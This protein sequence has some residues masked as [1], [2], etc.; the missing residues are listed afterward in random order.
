MAR[1]INCS[2]EVDDGAYF[3]SHCGT[4]ITAE[5]QTTN[6]C[7]KCGDQLY[8]DDAFC[9]NCGNKVSSA[10][11]MPISQKKS[12]PKRINKK[13]KQAVSAKK[14][15]GPISRVFRFLFWVGLI[16]IGLLLIPESWYESIDL[17]GFES[18]SSSAQVKEVTLQQ[19]AKTVVPEPFESVDQTITPEGTEVSHGAIR[20]I[21][22]PGSV[23]A[24]KNIQIKK[25]LGTPPSGTATGEKAFDAIAIGEPYDIGPDGISFDKPVTF[26]LSYDPA[27]LPK[28]ISTSSLILSY[29]D[30][31]K[32]VKVDAVHDKDK[33][34]FT[35]SASVFP[36]SLFHIL[37][38]PII[39]VGGTYMI[40]TGKHK[41]VFQMIWD[42]IR[43]NW[44]HEMVKPKNKSVQ[45]FSKRLRINDGGNLVSMDD[46]DD[47][48]KTLQK[49]IKK[50]KTIPFGFVDKYNKKKFI[51]LT[52]RYD[53]DAEFVKPPEDYIGKIDKSG[54]F[55]D[56]IDMTNIYVSMLRAKGIQVK[57]VA[58]YTVGGGPHAWTELVIGSEVYVVDEYGRLATRE[59][60]AKYVK[61]PKPGDSY[62][63]MWDE[64]GTTTYRS[65]WYKPVLNIVQPGSKIYAQ[66]G[67]KHTFSL[68][69]L[70]IPSN[71]LFSW[72][73]NNIGYTIPSRNKTFSYK[74]E[75]TGTFPL[76]CRAR[77]D[78]KEV[79]KT[80]SFT[81]H[82]TENQPMDIADC[83][84]NVFHLSTPDEDLDFI[85]LTPEELFVEA[86]KNQGKSLTREQ[87]DIIISG[88]EE[89]FNSKR[90]YYNKLLPASCYQA[91]KSGKLWI[92]WHGSHTDHRAGKQRTYYR[93]YQNKND[94]KEEDAMPV[95]TNPYSN[96]GMESIIPDGD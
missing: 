82:G 5:E 18:L 63:K 78:G 92:I 50:D 7:S 39:V 59:D 23:S 80:I 26:S 15:R 86:V 51:S 32:W 61:Y 75:G 74:F 40:A 87:K 33:N 42:P 4:E 53:P 84:N 1:C 13:K 90:S 88:R 60:Y 70:G 44:I 73:L 83:K 21:F 89:D 64:N 8:E 27:S 67:K 19:V 37:G 93:G 52:K 41:K 65:D 45:D 17:E 66:D 35:S 49:L 47:F 81:V 43:R 6:Y 24:D 56:C 28:E 31:Q 91:V 38:I 29:F 62:R 22:P 95:G 57:G 94:V 79:K 76:T 58:G 77:W 14:K 9:G 96:Y 20:V 71:A 12:R 48:D 72:N 69:T 16:F 46:M 30:G 68:T 25:V 3:C 10:S 55:G 11:T 85:L 36:G 54:K 34:T 2:M